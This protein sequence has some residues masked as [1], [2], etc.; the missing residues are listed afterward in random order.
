MLL[1]T[2]LESRARKSTK[3]NGNFKGIKFMSNQR[4]IRLKE[5]IYLTGLTRSSIYRLMAIGSF[6]KQI[7]VGER[8]IAWSYEQIESWVSDKLKSAA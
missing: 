3:D 4:L 8:C 1:I 6:P 5:V 2:R 7:K